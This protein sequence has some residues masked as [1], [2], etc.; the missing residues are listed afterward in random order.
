MIT[1]IIP[2][3][4]KDDNIYSTI[5]SFKRIK[6]KDTKLLIINNTERQI[7]SNSDK[8]VIIIN[9]GFN[10]FVNPAW[11]LGVEKSTTDYVCCLN[12]DILIDLKFIYEYI[13]KTKVDF[14]GFDSNL[15]RSN[16]ECPVELVNHLDKN[17]RQPGFGQFILL[18]KKEVGKLQ[19]LY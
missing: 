2:T 8:R 18:K 13:K 7:E 3:L 16:V 4:W 14:L 1:F 17:K 12:D 9:M 10:S 15:N 5:D 19:L 11:S 6:D